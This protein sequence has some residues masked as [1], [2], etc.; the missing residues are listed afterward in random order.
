MTVRN[1][2]FHDAKAIYLLIKEH[3]QEVLARSIS[4]IIQNIDRFLVCSAGGRVVGTVSWQ[5]LPEIAKS[6][7]PSIEIK[8][9]AVTKDFQGRGAGSALVR[10][11][12]R[13]IRVFK[14]AQIVVLTFSPEFFA[15]FGFKVVPKESLMHK[16][17]LGCVNCTKYDS[18]FTCPEVAMAMAVAGPERDAG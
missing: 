15:R 18:P 6:S 3:P 8:S 4:D 10:A 2:G 1:A 16:L 13:R 9:L 14:P 7:S 17:Y 12:I 11:V 5:I